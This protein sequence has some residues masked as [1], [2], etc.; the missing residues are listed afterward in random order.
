LKNSVQ[1]MNFKTI[2]TGII[3]ILLA[4]FFGACKSYKQHLMFKYEEGYPFAQFQADAMAAERNH[5]IQPDDYIQIEVY[6]KSGER[7]IDPD[8]ELNRSL[9]GDRN[10]VVSRPEPEYLVKPD[11]TVKLPMVG[12][13]KLAGFTIDGAS[14]V[15]EEAYARFYEDTYVLIR[16]TNKRVIVLGAPG[17]LLIPL[18]NENMTVAEVVALA[19]GINKNTKAHNLRLIRGDEVFLIDL[20]TLDGYYRTNQT[21]LSGDILYIEPVPRVLT[22]SATEISLIVSTI[23]ALT[24]LLLLILTLK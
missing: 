10:T 15:L 4:S 12:D 6:T 13:I 23:T 7:I 14:R 17:G 11:S 19:G 1:N 2:K 16:F 9:T 24:T 22:Q 3:I 20:S 18:E 21:V 8:L 5:I